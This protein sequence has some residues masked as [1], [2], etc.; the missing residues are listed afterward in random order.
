MV[1]L[2]SGT[3]GRVLSR[4]RNVPAGMCVKVFVPGTRGRTAV[5]NMALA[6]HLH[7]H[8]RAPSDRVVLP[9]EW[10]ELAPGTHGLVMDEHGRS[11][12]KVVA[13]TGG[14]LV[15]D[16]FGELHRSLCAAVAYLHGF[17]V[18][19][20]DISPPN[21]LEHRA[22]DGWVLIDFDLWRPFG[23]PGHTAYS[24]ALRPPELLADPERTTLRPAAEAWAVGM[25]LDFANTGA[26]AAW[27]DSTA[28]ETLRRL[29]E[30]FGHDQGIPAHLWRAA[31]G[32]GSR[33]RPPP[34][35][36]D[37]YGDL[38]RLDPAE[39]RAIGEVGELPPAPGL[40]G[41]REISVTLRDRHIEALMRAKPET[42]QVALLAITLIDAALGD[43]EIDTVDAPIVPVA[44]L[45]AA[46]ALMIEEPGSRRR[47][48][49][50]V[51]H[52]HQIEPATLT[53]A[54]ANAWSGPLGLHLWD[55]AVTWATVDE[56]VRD[57]EAFYKRIDR[58]M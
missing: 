40:K 27:R 24:V 6:A 38:V 15:G 42:P 18:A 3:Y 51:S 56:A 20:A 52:K 19:S 17:G 29:I 58:E 12:Q 39:R 44:A 30:L 32:V 34:P 54:S 45:N 47:A 37:V 31:I 2:G 10:L 13:D 55:P 35:D 49:A 25:T 14:P 23:A 8:S 4:C 36:W 26:Y 9:T 41:D 53:I 50:T 1:E 16:A 7:L 5:R 33:P 46:T 11:L 21:V 57:P 43:A 22:G 28:A 48:F